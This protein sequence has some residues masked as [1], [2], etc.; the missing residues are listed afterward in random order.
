M[1]AIGAGCL[2]V[3]RIVFE[4]LPRPWFVSERDQDGA[5]TGEDLNFCLAAAAAGFLSYC[6]TELVSGHFTMVAMTPDLANVLPPDALTSADWP[7][8]PLA[9]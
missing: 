8:A 3:R 5:G 9:P 6:D 4:T 7:E 2:L 1:R